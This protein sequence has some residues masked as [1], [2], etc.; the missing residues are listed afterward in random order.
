MQTLLRGIEL[1][2]TF[3][4]RR[5]ID[6]DDNNQTLKSYQ[7][8]SGDELY[9]FAKGCSFKVYVMNLAG[10][11]EEVYVR[12]DLNVAM[13]KEEIGNVFEVDPEKIWIVYGRKPL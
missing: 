5:L 3:P 12:P 4:K 1:D 8:Q 10:K 7:I 6:L 11:T 13:M 9:V 2:Q